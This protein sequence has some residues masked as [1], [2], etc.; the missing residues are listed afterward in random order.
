MVSA[1][2][3]LVPAGLY[4][5]NTINNTSYIKLTKTYSH[6]ILYISSLLSRSAYYAHFNLSCYANMCRFLGR[7]FRPFLIQ[8]IKWSV[9]Q[10]FRFYESKT[11]GPLSFRQFFLQSLYQGLN[12][13]FVKYSQCYLSISNET[14]CLLLSQTQILNANLLERVTT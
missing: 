14:C 11:P 6:N 2:S 1:Y 12:T 7:L 13:L 10:D 9:S 4:N 8:Y 3:Q 5:I